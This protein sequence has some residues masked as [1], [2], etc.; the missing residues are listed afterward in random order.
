MK[1]APGAFQKLSETNGPWQVVEA[2][3]GELK[4][5]STNWKQIHGKLEFLAQLLTDF[6]PDDVA[7]SNPGRGRGEFTVATCMKMAAEAMNNPN[8]QARAMAVEVRGA[9]WIR[10]AWELLRQ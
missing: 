2:L 10:L 8:G 7:E 4:K 6:G 9:A 1:Y 5:K 3:S